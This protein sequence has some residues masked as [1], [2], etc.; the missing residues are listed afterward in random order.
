MKSATIALIV[1]T[2]AA[3]LAGPPE[4]NKELL[5]KLANAPHVVA[6]AKN[7][8][9]V[10]SNPF[11]PL[12]HMSAP[13]KLIHDPNGLC[14]WKGRYHLF[15]QYKM[16]GRGWIIH[17]GHAYSDDLLHWKDLPVAIKPTIE[18]SCFS[19]QTV[20]DTDRVI[21]MYHGVGAGN[22]IATSSDPLLLRWTKHP[23]NP[24]IPLH[25]KD[26]PYR[27]FDPCIWK[28]ANGYYYSLSGSHKGGRLRVNCIGETHIFRSKDL[29]KW[30]WLGP[31]YT[32]TTF[33]EP[34][35]D[36]VVPN[37][38]PVGNGKHLLLC[39]SHKRAGRGY[40]G[41]FD[42]A[43]ARFKA[44]YHFR[45]NHGTF[46]HGS[47]HAPSATV[48]DKGRYIG[49]FNVKEASGVRHKGWDGIMSLPRV[50]SLAKDNSL[51]INPIEEIEKLRFDH[52]RVA[53]MSIAS[54]KEE[55]LQG[56]G[57]KAIEIKAALRP[58]KAK[59]VGLKVLQ[60][61]DGREYT[62]IRFT[63]DQKVTI[64]TSHSSLKKLRPRKP[65]TAPLVLGK[66]EPLDLR[67]FIDR[68]IVEVFANER[69]CVSLRVY[70]TRHT[71]RYVSVFSEGGD[72]K[73]LSLDVWQMRSVWPEL[74]GKEG[75]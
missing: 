24:V 53:G 28:E 43:K 14:Q 49:I 58:G 17:W 74:K 23:K 59:E 52:K 75:K 64:D 73:L 16:P 34:G 7:R 9:L 5:A 37:F 32:D 71:A 25:K 55:M 61:P 68:T 22:M 50:F 2:S 35:E 54:G 60:T 41:S 29:A 40:V 8:K 56:V 13:D 26:S 38:W 15:F 36:M 20:V 42:L 67:I 57:G 21:A 3:A 47:I 6:C 46:R 45:A 62:V 18:R 10:A 48:D 19:G 30:E 1:A 12:Y 65:E 11:R 72:A 63:A 66:D 44:D 33:A 27:V 4:L 39:F 31:M 51:R 69:Q 70:P